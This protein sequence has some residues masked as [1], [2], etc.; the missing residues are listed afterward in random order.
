MGA[1]SCL[2]KILVNCPDDIL[3]EKLDEITDKMS[4]VVKNKNFLAH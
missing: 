4:Q 1:I 3:F 2:T